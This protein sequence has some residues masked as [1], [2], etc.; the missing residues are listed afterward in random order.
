MAR[1]KPAAQPAGGPDDNPPVDRD[2]P[3]VEPAGG[4]ED[5]DAL[6][7]LLDGLDDP[8]G[9]EVCVFEIN[10]DGTR[11]M[12]ARQG[13][14]EFDP[15]AFGEQW[16]G[17]TYEMRLRDVDTKRWGRQRRFSVSARVPRRSA[18]PATP[19]AAPTPAAADPSRDM[20]G[21]MMSLV[22]N[23]AQQQTA[24]LTALIGRPQ[25]TTPLGELVQAA[26]LLTGR[27]PSSPI[28]ELL[29][30]VERIQKL[31][32]AGGNAAS[33]SDEV[34]LAKTL[35][36][37]IGEML[38]QQPAARAAAPTSAGGA[39][40]VAL[41]PASPA[42]THAAGPP[43]PPRTAAPHTP[44]EHAQAAAASAAIDTLSAIIVRV[45]ID[46]G[47]AID[48]GALERITA[49]ALDAI[50]PD[51][52]GDMLDLVPRG[53]LPDYVLAATPAMLR[54]QVAQ[55]RDALQRIEA[56]LR[57]DLDDAG[58]ASPPAQQQEEHRVT[59]A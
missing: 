20:L 29:E 13:V 21:L 46:A 51:A 5:Q 14:S 31:T 45:G 23:Q 6:Q 54:E 3:L 15:W 40:A 18:T 28:G 42:A 4:A 58:E 57:D 9:Y 59:T 35:A 50:D 48:G 52:L 39:G 17:G 10:P 32:A 11:H 37:L 55:H 27:G 33:A 24:I 8:T 49:Q 1:R 47:G 2:A 16:G 22:Q 38:R 30:G 26:Q 12:L 44:R 25:Q 53:H 41:P 43:S 34:E 7:A 36:P 19:A 56:A